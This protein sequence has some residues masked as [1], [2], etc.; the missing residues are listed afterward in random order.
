MN[1]IHHI[2]FRLQP[3][4]RR[5]KIEAGLFDEIKAHLEMAAEAN[6]AAGM[7]PEE[8]RDL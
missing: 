7:S 2:A 5:G 6:L 4:F 3:L 1:W 8:A